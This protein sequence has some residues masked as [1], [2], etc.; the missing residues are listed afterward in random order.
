M[1]SHIHG[2]RGANATTNPPP[3]PPP[4]Y[5]APAFRVQPLA[6]RGTEPA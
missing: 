5:E 4:G 3:S 2:L 1:S 6:S